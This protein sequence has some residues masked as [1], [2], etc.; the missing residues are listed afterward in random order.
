MS[1][2]EIISILHHYKRMNS[3]KYHLIKLGI[4][5]SFARGEARENSDIDIVVEQQKPDLFILGSIKTEL[6][7]LL[8]MPV[9]VIRLHKRMNPFLKKRIDREA[10]YV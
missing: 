6:E 5:G 9:D 4:F 3:Q 2:D 10:I 8:G 1:R 7:E